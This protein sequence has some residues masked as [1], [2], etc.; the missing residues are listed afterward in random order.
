MRI[1]FQKPAE[2]E[3]QQPESQVVANPEQYIKHP[4][5][6]RWELSSCCIRQED[7]ATESLCL[8]TLQLSINR[9]DSDDHFTFNGTLTEFYRPSLTSNHF[10]VI[11]SSTLDYCFTPCWLKSC[12]QPELIMSVLATQFLLSLLRVKHRGVT[13]LFSTLKCLCLFVLWV[14]EKWF[15]KKML[16]QTASHQRLAGIQTRSTIAIVLFKLLSFCIV[17]DS[18]RS[19]VQSV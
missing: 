11:L 19:I 3:D 15:L 16:F 6:N 18:F 14:K 8:Q 5:Q 1:S 7:I 9:W 17:D 12:Y 10:R 4:L 13:S 2:T